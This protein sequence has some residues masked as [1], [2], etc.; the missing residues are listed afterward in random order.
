MRLGFLLLTAWFGGAIAVE[1][2]HGNAFIFPA[3][4]LTI[5]WI[6]AFLRD[7]SILKPFVQPQAL[8]A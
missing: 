7:R 3:V 5:L 2:S 4:I 6:A 1:L 8:P